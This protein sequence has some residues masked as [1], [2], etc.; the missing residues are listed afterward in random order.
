MKNDDFTQQ[1]ID[2]LKIQG[3]PP[4]NQQAI[5]DKIEAAANLRFANS[6]TELL[7][8]EQLAEVDKLEASNKTDEEVV[9]WIEQQIPNHDEI[10]RAVML[11]ITDEVIGEQ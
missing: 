2:K 8:E 6:L 1:I 5:L 10:M 11:D 4:E 3:L 9:T 7:T